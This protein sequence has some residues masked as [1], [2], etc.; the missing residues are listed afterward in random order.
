[1]T[2]VSLLGFYLW[3]IDRSNGEAERSDSDS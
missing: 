2:A 3:F 1:V